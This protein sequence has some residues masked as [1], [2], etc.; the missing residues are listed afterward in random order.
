M[1]NLSLAAK[2]ELVFGMLLPARHR[3]V[4]LAATLAVAIVALGVSGGAARNPDASV[5][6]TLIVAGSLAAVAG[7]R[8]MAPGA[9]LSAARHAACRWWLPPA[10]RLVGTAALLV[11]TVAVCAVGL[12]GP[13]ADWTAV[14]SLSVIAW[15]YATA[16]AALVQAA[17]PFL[18]A[19]AAGTAV[20]LLVWTGGVPP[21]AWQEL[22]QGLPHLQRPLVIGWNVLPTA[23]RAHR[24]WTGGYGSD[25]AVLT[26][27]VV[28]G[29]LVSAW[30]ASWVGAVTSS[31][32]RDR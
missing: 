22:L 1:A 25:V 13:H 4:R 2:A 27:W 7:S 3:S 26:S 19:S 18:G 16:T 8:L 31:G 17:T 29:T 23:W 11:P 30:G 15:V 9:A 12:L 14:T 21:S 6:L 20:L 32:R 5:Y 28:M 10:G 24:W